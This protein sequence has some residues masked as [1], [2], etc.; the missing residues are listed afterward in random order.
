MKNFQ[1]VFAAA[2]LAPLLHPSLA[3]AEDTS[4]SVERFRWSLNSDGVLSVESAKTGQHKE[5]TLGAWVGYANDPLVA[6]TEASDE[7]TRIGALVHHRVGG[8]LVASLALWHRLE[9]GAEVPL[10]LYQFRSGNFGGSLQPIAGIDKIG[11]G[12]LRIIPKFS[13]LRQP[14]H[15]VDLALIPSFTLP[16][17][18]G[19]NY[20]GD[21]GATFLPELAVSRHWGAAGKLRT[22]LN[23]NYRARKNTTTAN[24]R[25]GDE[26]GARVGIGYPLTRLASGRAIDLGVTL[27]ASANAYRATDSQFNQVPLEVNA[28]VTVPVSYIDVLLATGA[29]LQAGFGTPD[30]RALVGLRFHNAGHATSHRAQPTPILLDT[31]HDEIVDSVDSC[32]TETEDRDGFEDT[33]GCP[34]LDN[35]KDGITDL[36]DKCPR[37]PE[38]ANGYRDDDGCPDVGDRDID[39]IADDQDRCPDVAEDVDGF[40]D[41][42]GCVDADNDGDGVLDTADRCPQQAGSKD[43]AGCPDGDRDS[44]TVVDRLDNCP[45]EA[46]PAKNQGCKTKQLVQVV[47]GQLEILEQVFFDTNKARI[48]KRSF[49]LL[50]NAAAVI[51]AHPE[52]RFEVQGHT[53]DRGNDAANQ[54]LSSRRAAAVVKYL[55]EK[56]V[57]ADQLESKGFGESAPIDSNKSAAGRARN[58]RVVFN[59]IGA[60]T[61]TIDQPSNGPTGPI[62]DR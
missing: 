62:N 23:V 37:E 1:L 57:P 41:A 52:L 27:A 28:G 48:Q 30:W 39:G 22:L 32:P 58:R 9:L 31:D 35:D 38:T 53:D 50:T 54:D 21:D 11:L 42:D 8:S 56:S 61:T 2:L 6:Y 7:R 26:L 46:G 24:L 14:K 49:K 12:D 19:S 29:G 45:D 15:G 3:R 40:Q 60:A 17:G 36:Q 55:I 5:F 51:A 25:V 33:D 34:D 4:F 13:L 18:G 47:D 20:F 10:V 16:T 43:N 44:D 59:I